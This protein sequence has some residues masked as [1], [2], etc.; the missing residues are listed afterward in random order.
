MD[1]NA[2]TSTA[3][4]KGLTLKNV[5]ANNFLSSATAAKAL[6]NNLRIG[7]VGAPG[8]IV[9][10][11]MAGTSLAP[12]ASTSQSTAIKPSAL[13]TAMQSSTATTAAPSFNNQNNVRQEKVKQNWDILISALRSKANIDS[14]DPFLETNGNFQSRHNYLHAT[15]KENWI[16]FSIIISIVISLSILF[17]FLVFKFFPK[18]S[19]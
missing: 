5:V 6:N 1:A 16:F 9:I 12:V 8:K 18:Y 19:E 10:A 2:S 14:D 11:S 4:A 15:D 13:A 17:C 7:E 3:R